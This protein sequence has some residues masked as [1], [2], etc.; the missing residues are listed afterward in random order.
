MAET[1]SCWRARWCQNH[2]WADRRK[3]HI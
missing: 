1:P 3:S 2:W